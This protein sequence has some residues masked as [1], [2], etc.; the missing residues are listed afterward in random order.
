MAGSGLSPASWH[1]ARPAPLCAVRKQLGNGPANL[2][3]LGLDDFVVWRRIG[4]LVEF[5]QE[6][7]SA[8]IAA[9]E[10]D[11]VCEY[12]AKP[13]YRDCDP[14]GRGH[15]KQLPI[16]RPMQ[17]IDQPDSK[18]ANAR[19]RYLGEGALSSSNCWQFRT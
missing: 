19:S 12:R 13:A 5:V 15:G 2:S 7:L 9:D 4:Q 16:G 11:D 17:L 6:E 18:G 1:S 3:R 14:G 10:I 8:N